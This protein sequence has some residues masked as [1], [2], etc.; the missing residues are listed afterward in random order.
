MTAVRALLHSHPEQISQTGAISRCIDACFA[1]V[2]TCTA[3]ADACLAEKHVEKL[4]TCIRL[5]LDCAAVCTATGHIITRANKAGHRQ[6]Q[7]AQLTTC[8]AFSRAC[9]AECARH[10]AMHQHCAL[11]AEACNKFAAACVDLLTSMRM[12]A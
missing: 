2:E 1:S 4:I 7:E 8:I 11:C 3:C 12:P 10:A 5:N 6:L 9:A